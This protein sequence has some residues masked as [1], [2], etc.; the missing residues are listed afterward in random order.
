MQNA[1]FTVQIDTEPLF[2]LQQ[3]FSIFNFVWVKYWDGYLCH[4]RIKTEKK[5]ERI[6]FRCT[7]SIQNPPTR[8]TWIILNILTLKS[9]QET[10]NYLSSEYCFNQ[11]NFT[12]ECKMLWDTPD[13]LVSHYWSLLTL[14]RAGAGGGEARSW[15]LLHL[16][17]NNDTNTVELGRADAT[18]DECWFRFSSYCNT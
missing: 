16:W 12:F 13:M 2:Y 15:P 3:Q 10:I 8:T 1:C 17:H 6:M 9:K 14:T 4:P 7:V 18:D 5:M 11:F